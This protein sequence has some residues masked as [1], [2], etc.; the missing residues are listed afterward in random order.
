LIARITELGEEFQAW[1]LALLFDGPGF[2]D[3][4]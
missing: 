4:F 3:G 2:A 1:L